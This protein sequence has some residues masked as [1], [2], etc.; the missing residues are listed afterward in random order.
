MRVVLTGASGQLGAYLIEALR[1]GGHE[2]IAWSG[3]D[4]GDRSGVALTPVDLTNEEG[5]KRAL[6]AADPEAILHAAALSSAEGVRREPTLGFAINVDATARLARWCARNERRLLFTST[7]LVFSGRSSWNREDDPADSI[8]AYGKTKRLAEPLVTAAPRGLVARVSLLYGH[9][10]CGRPSF[11]ETTI[12][13]VRRGE[14]QTLFED[15]FRTPLDLTTAAEFLTALLSSETTG[16]VH[17][18]G[19]ERISRFELIRRSAQALG[20]DPQLVRSNRRAEVTL[21]E[22][23]PADVSLDTSRLRSLL[24]DISVPSIE[25]AI[26]QG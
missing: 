15:E 17:V 26:K 21:V 7:D 1:R 18:A 16:V 2:V 22:P 14:V 20:L 11:F 13:K 3:T 12:A 23:R 24:P 8:L 10:R 19:T 4:A 9:S 25:A 6:E 5:V